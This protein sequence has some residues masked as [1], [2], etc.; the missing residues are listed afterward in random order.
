MPRFFV[1][2]EQI[3]HNEIKIIG[4]DCKHISTVLRSKVG[5]K[6][7]VCN[8]DSMDFECSIREINKQEILLA[9][10][11]CEKSKSEPETKVTLFQAMP[12][13]D[14]L[15]LIIQKCVELGIDEIVPMN[16]EFTI[17]KWNGKEDK[18]LV[19][20]QKISEGAAKQSGRGKIPNIHPVVSFRQ[21]LEMSNS[22]ELT[23]LA[24]EKETDTTLKSVLKTAKA[25]NVAYFV[26]SEGGFCK[27]E[28]LLCKEKNVQTISLGQRILRTETAGFTI[29]ANILYEWE[30]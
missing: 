19:R 16:T 30:G 27:E 7:G 9:V 11:S 14:K 20:L 10:L 24:Y 26:G 29:L 17:V 6:I 25:K 3:Q 21:A 4:E 15:E 5:D 1:N 18:K 23:M 28:I 13:A 12:K 22:F 8:G 2:K